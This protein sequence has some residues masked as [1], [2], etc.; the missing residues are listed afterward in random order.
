MDDH[1]SG[2]NDR[3][4]V[5]VDSRNRFAELISVVPSGQVIPIA[6]D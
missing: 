2:M 6:M 3:D 1:P 4:H 5:L